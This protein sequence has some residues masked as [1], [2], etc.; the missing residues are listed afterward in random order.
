[1]GSNLNLS[2]ELADMSLILMEIIKQEF[3]VGAGKN[4]PTMTQFKMLYV[5]RDGVGHVGKLAEAFGISQ[6]AASKMVDIM[7]KDGLLKRFPHPH[8][9]RQIELRLTPK[10]SASIE[11]MYKRAYAKIDERLEDLPDAKK[12]NLVKH[13]QEVK[14]LLSIDSS[15]VNE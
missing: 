2:R 13:L 14:A 3:K 6:P 12:K 1:M 4:A 5:I 10:A 7:V 8:D 11:T 9:R 15:L